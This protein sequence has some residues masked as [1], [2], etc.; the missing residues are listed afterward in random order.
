[1]NKLFNIPP[2]K[3]KSV[4][5]LATYKGNKIVAKLIRTL[6]EF[7]E[8]DIN[9]VGYIDGNRIFE[10]SVFSDKEIGEL[11]DNLKQKIAAY[12]LFDFPE[13]YLFDLKE[14][15][16]GYVNSFNV[17]SGDGFLFEACHKIKEVRTSGNTIIPEKRI[18]I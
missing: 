13:N 3:R 5:Y 6:K 16:L 17:F 7:S 4:F 18:V 14:R 9:D 15:R 1:M 10:I 11:V 2:V 12:L 8:Y